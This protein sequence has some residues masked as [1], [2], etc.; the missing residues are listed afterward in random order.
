MKNMSGVK[1]TKKDKDFFLV[2]KA[3]C[4]DQSA[5]NKIFLKY[6]SSLIYQISS[7]VS[8]TDVV[9]DIMM[10]TYEKAFERFSKFQPDYQLSSWLIRIAVNC[11]I[12]HTRKRSRV[13]IQSIDENDED[14]DRPTLQIVDRGYNPEEK[15]A[16]DQRIKFL[17]EA[18]KELPEHLRKV[19]QLRYFEEFSYEE[20]ADEMDVD[21]TVIKNYLHK[22]KKNLIDI[23]HR[24]APKDIQ[25]F[26]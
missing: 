10:E 18:M 8:E 25:V 3:L 15:F 11:A 26:L 6:R 12:D 16:K 14:E 22:A 5:Y 13:S 17:R 23:V 7:I 20:M 2:Q 21:V 9:E 1:L 19:L 24:I 4:G